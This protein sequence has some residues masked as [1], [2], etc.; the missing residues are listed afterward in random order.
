[1]PFR[2]AVSRQLAG[3]LAVLAH[4]HRLRIVEELGHQELDVASISA[5]LGVSHS[6]TSQHLAQLRAH[7]LVAERRAG[8]QVFYH[9]R[10]PKLARWLLDGLDVIESNAESTREIK[11]NLQRA[12]AAWALPG[13]SAS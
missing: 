3:I 11:K 2:A 7:R 10:N 8:R 13:E 5:L 12:R 9:L 1:M 6:G 4:P